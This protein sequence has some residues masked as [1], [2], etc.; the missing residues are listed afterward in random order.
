MQER[1]QHW[2]LHA[3][4]VFRTAGPA[5][6]SNKNIRIPIIWSVLCWGFKVIMMFSQLGQKLGGIILTSR[7]NAQNH[8]DCIPQKTNGWN[9][10]TGG[11][12]LFLLVQGDI[13]RFHVSFLGSIVGCFTGWWFQ[14]FFYFHPY[15]GKW[16]NLTH[17]FQMG[18]ETTNQFII[19]PHFGPL[20]PMFFL[21]DDFVVSPP[22]SCAEIWVSLWV[23][24]VGWVHLRA[25]ENIGFV[26]GC[27][28]H[29]KHTTISIALQGGGFKYLYIY[30]HVCLLCSFRS[31]EMFQFEWYFSN[32]SK[33]PSSFHLYIYN[34]YISFSSC[35]QIQFTHP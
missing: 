5:I 2:Q 32:G 30:I 31:R 9:P 28:E 15:L 1:C 10:K 8:H 25:E 20:W 3:H 24:L 6:A 22:T 14:I 21:G 26:A 18:W 16:S 4:I 13:F 23:A 29:I 19:L 35:S 17:I 11:V 34:I 7:K 33:P 27:D 12:Y